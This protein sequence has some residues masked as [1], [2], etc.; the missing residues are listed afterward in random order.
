M[1]DQELKQRTISLHNDMAEFQSR[2]KRRLT[3]HFWNRDREEMDHDESIQDLQERSVI[4]K[5]QQSEFIKEFVP[6]LEIILQEYERRNIEPDDDARSFETLRWWAQ[7]GEPERIL[8]ALS[9]LA[10]KLETEE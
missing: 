9:S 2:K 3:R 6:R 4:R 7:R 5:E 1:S 8:P 10:G